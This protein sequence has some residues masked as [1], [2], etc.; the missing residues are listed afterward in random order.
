MSAST[1]APTATPAHDIADQLRVAG[2]L[3]ADARLV[4]STGAMPHAFLFLDFAPALGMP[5]RARVD[6]GTELA[7]H[8]AAEALLPQLRT[9]AAISV[10]GRALQLR[11]DHHMAALAVVDAQAV[12][13]LQHPHRPAPPV[14]SAPQPEDHHAH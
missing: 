10:A 7:D 8:M 11:S 5:Y 13:L 9:G 2:R 14:A 4:H 3:T 12:L 6:L 1:P